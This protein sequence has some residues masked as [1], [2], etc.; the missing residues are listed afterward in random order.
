MRSWLTVRWCAPA[1]ACG[2]RAGGVSGPELLGRDGPGASGRTGGGGG[3]GVLPD[4]L[5]CGATTCA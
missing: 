3:G 2:G 5:C 1:G 4:A